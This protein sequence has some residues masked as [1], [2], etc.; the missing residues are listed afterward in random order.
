MTCPFIHRVSRT[1]HA[2][3]GESL[4][5]PQGSF[6]ATGDP[7]MAIPAFMDND[8]RHSALPS[9]APPLNEA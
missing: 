9:A 1:G 2:Q 7:A 4:E 6:E 5:A 3:D 8:G